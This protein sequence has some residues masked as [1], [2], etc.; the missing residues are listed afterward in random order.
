MRT[1]YAM[2]VC[3]SLLFGMTGPVR[4]EE[5][6]EP[7]KARLLGLADAEKMV[8][9]ALA[10]ARENGWKV[11]I[12]VVDDGG[13]LVMLKRMDGMAIGCISVAIN[14]AKTAALYG[15]PTVAFQ[16]TLNDDKFLALLSIPDLTPIEGGLPIVGD[17]KRVVGAI[18]VSGVDAADD[19]K[20]AAAGRKALDWAK[21]D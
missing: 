18:G 3:A 14:K 5:S 7:A 21:Q 15:K 11:A 13:H 2:L 20:I 16:K 10:K 17:G 6:G 8:D 1:T 12:A 19:G 9:V 4:A